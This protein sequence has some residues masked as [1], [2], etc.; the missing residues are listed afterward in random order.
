M[1]FHLITLF[2]GSSIVFA[3]NVGAQSP[4][5]QSTVHV[6]P[7]FVDGTTAE[8]RSYISTLQVSSTDFFSWTWCSLGL[9]S[10]PPTTLADAWGRKQT[11]TAF[12]F[13]LD[14]NGW[15]I[16]QSQGTQSLRSGSAILQCDRP[17]T[18]HLVYTLNSNGTV[19]AETT[20]SA[21]PPGRMVQILAD[22]RRDSRLGVAMM[23][24]FTVQALY[25]ISVIDM[26]NRLVSLTHIQIPAAGTFS[27]FL[28]EFAAVPR[29][30]RGVIMIETVS[31][32]D[33]YAAGLR[34]NQD[35]FTAIPAMVRW[36]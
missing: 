35:S 1:R 23:N 19:S 32:I 31:G 25:R 26:D 17:V 14:P 30:Y 28:D 8:S 9:W 6:F 10:M 33:V 16:L 22:Q 11:N 2:I 18:A 13:V 29:D 12:N 15:Q 20:V 34:F 21:A 24:P 3:G 4:D 27:R 5:F 7:Q 36:R